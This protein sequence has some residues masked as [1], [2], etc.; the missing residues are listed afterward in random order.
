MGR[1]RSTRLG[2]WAVI[3]PALAGCQV[4]PAKAWNL[5]QLHQPDGR[6]Q[7]EGR[8]VG[9]VEFVLERALGALRATGGKFESVEPGAERIEDPLGACFENVLALAGAEPDEKVVALQVASF[10]WL[11]VDCTYVLSRE[12]C[13]LALG[14]LAGTL[15]LGPEP[16]P[17]PA[18]PATPEEVQAAFEALVATTR[19]VV[20]A[21]G[22]AGDALEQAAGDVL[23]LSLDRAGAVRLLR[24]VNA[25]LADD[26]RGAVLAPLR[27]LRL[28][29]A[30]RAAELALRAGLADPDGRVRA[31]AFEGNVRA[32]AAERGAR[33]RW[34]LLEPMEELENRAILRLR[35]LDFLARYGVPPAPPG[36]DPE[37]FAREVQAALVEVLREGLGGPEAVAACRALARI[38]G[39]PTSLRPE[40]WLARW[41]AESAAPSSP[42]VPVP[43]ESL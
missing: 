5:Q 36:E 24:G 39:E 22:L 12:R 3:P 18:E 15:H 25:L 40:D 9:D 33:L 26:E 43:E 8:I 13:F 34:A 41:R 29:L 27:E 28:V 38:R 6:P 14:E 17:V 42:A 32:F 30:R 21:P 11:G 23:A 10:A 31:A 16:P 1:T 20:G 2:L 19:E 37:T 4:A 35:A 7:H